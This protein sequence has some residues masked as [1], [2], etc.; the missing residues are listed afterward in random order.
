[1]HE[2]SIAQN[3]VNV[4]EEQLKDETFSRVLTVNIEIGKFSC[5][6]AEALEFCF[7]AVAKDTILDNSRLAIYNVHPEVLC[8]ICN[9]RSN[10]NMDNPVLICGYCKS[11]EVVLQ[12]GEEFQI[13]SVEVE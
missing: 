10:V 12:K 1:M 2:L 4:I 8:E 3:I 9:K 5:V 13:T 7:E 6:S 11:R